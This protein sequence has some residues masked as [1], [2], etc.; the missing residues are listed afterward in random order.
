MDTGREARE[1]WGTVAGS[2]PYHWRDAG[3]TPRTPVPTLVAHVLSQSLGREVSTADLWPDASRD[4]GLFTSAAAG[5][6]APWSRVGLVAVI[7]NWLISGMTDRRQNPGIT[8]FFSEETGMSPDLTCFYPHGD[9]VVLGGTAVDTASEEPDLTAAQAIIE[10]CAAIE[11]RLATAPVLEH[12]IGLR[13]TRTAIRVELDAS[14]E[15]PIVHNYG[16]GG[17]G[18]TCSWG[19]AAQTADL[20][21]TRA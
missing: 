13:P 7:E 2:A 5:L 12:R 10:R 18:V 19:C 4:V 8:A 11:P 15:V 3:R 20:A 9:T 17:A 1:G 14:G 21:Q 16:H 6:A